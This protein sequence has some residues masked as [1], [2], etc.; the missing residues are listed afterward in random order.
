MRAIRIEKLGGPESLRLQD[1]PVPTPN[2]ED[3]LIAVRG[4]GVN[5]ADLLIIRG[6]YQERPA[7]PFTP[8]VEIAGEIIEIG[9]RVS[10]F[11]AGD[12]VMA[13]V[14]LGGYAER[15]VVRAADAILIPEEME[16]IVAAGFPIAYGTAHVALAHRARLAAGE[17]L[18][19]H[20]AGGGVGLAAVEVGKAL[21]AT[22][23]A[24]AGSYDKLALAKAH[25]ADQLI[26]HTNESVRERVKTTVG[27]VDVVF[28]PVGGAAFDASLRCLN[29]EGRIVVVGFASGTIPSIP[30][31]ILLVKNVAV[32][33][34]YWGAYGR[35]DPDVQKSSFDALTTF[36][37]NG[38]LKPHIG[39]TFKLAE[40]S[41]ALSLLA[42]RQATGKVVLVTS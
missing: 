4:S 10:G 3:L 32:L 39:H 24:T 9:R 6:D 31:N 11:A 23:V 38:S 34:L 2:E 12:R 8:G 18:L 42:N 26:N 16:T 36:F 25:G 7:L 40:V 20:G 5:F 41:D 37:R 22:V 19:V 21:G 29:F 17:V 30:A 14:D 1:V 15:A 35:L 33:G 28:D 13:R 27:G